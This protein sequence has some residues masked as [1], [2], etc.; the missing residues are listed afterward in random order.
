MRA[1]HTLP[2]VAGSIGVMRLSIGATIFN[3]MEVS[4][5]CPPFTDGTARHHEKQFKVFK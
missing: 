4:F 3:A 5:D 1:R 2:A